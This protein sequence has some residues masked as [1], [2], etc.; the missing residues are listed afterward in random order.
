MS[1]AKKSRIR[2]LVQA[3]DKAYTSHNEKVMQ[4]LSRVV[5]PAIAMF[6]TSLRG[7]EA[8]ARIKLTSADVVE[9]DFYEEGVLIIWGNTKFEEGEQIHDD[10]GNLYTL[11]HED[12]MTL[13]TPIHIG[14][15][16]KLADT[17]TLQEIVVYLEGQYADAIEAMRRIRE[18]YHQQLEEQEHAGDLLADPMYSVPN[19]D[20]PEL[21]M[22][23]SEYS[24]DEQFMIRQAYKKNGNKLQ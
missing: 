4:E 22:D 8:G 23:L 24:E 7:Q 21:D 12:A 16:L 17:G 19:E 9:H 18:K 1:G 15:P 5:E 20:L 6:V 3:R 10:N 11:S 14:L 2:Q 13:S